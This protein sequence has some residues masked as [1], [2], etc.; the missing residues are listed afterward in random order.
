MGLGTHMAVIS[1]PE[2]SLS[3][4]RR[5][6]APV[7]RW[8]DAQ[9]VSARVVGEGPAK[10]SSW[11]NLILTLLVVAG[12][13]WD[14]GFVAVYVLA[15]PAVAVTGSLAYLTLVIGWRAASARHDL[16]AGVTRTGG[17]PGQ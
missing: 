14:L 12:G 17:R 5:R 13:F 8:L 4:P 9:E 7:V 10:P 16:L 1:R 2:R 15:P 6:A 3:G 11:S